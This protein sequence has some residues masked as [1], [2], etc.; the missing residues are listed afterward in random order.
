MDE[1]IPKALVT[2]IAKLRVFEK[3]TKGVK[4]K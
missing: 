3:E 1:P 4:W 2:K